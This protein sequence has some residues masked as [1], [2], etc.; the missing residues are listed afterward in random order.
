MNDTAEHLHHPRSGGHLIGHDDILSSLTREQKRRHHGI[1]LSGPRGI[2]KATLAY[3]VA[4]HLFAARGESDLLGN[5]PDPENSPETPLIRAGSHPDMLVIE[6]ETDKAT[7]G[8]SVEQIRR[9]P[10]FL[11]HTPSRGSLRVV[12][13]DALDEMNFNG[14]NAMLKTLEEPPEQ[15]LI[16]LIH[17]GT[18]PIL[19][20]IRSRC[21]VVKLSPLSPEDTRHIISLNFP[22]ADAGWI[23]VAAVLSE[24]APGRVQ[25]IADSGAMDLYAETCAILASANASPLALDDVAQQWGQ[26]GARNSARRAIMRLFF[27]RL[28]RLSARKAAGY[29]DNSLHAGLDIENQAIEAITGRVPAP[30]LAELQQDMLRKT[31]EA[32]RLNLDLSVVAHEFLSELASA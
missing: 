18:V 5:A 22:D 28:A 10:P 7:S 15:A 1:I 21:R 3:R 9:V 19:P 17:H 26:G 8:I 14:A 27:D 31:D 6:T 12:L 24:G 25:M 11:S 20:T 13:I 29:F 16:L 2:G 4:E 30:K 23:D 32:K